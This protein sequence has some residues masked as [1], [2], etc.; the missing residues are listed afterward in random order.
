MRAEELAYLDGLIYTVPLLG[1]EVHAAG[2]HRRGT[3]L[4]RRKG[5]GWT[6]PCCSCPPGFE[7]LRRAW[8][9]RAAPDR[10]FAGRRPAH[11]GRTAIR[12]LVLLGE[13]GS[14]KTTTLLAAG[15]RPTP[16]P[17]RG[18]PAVRRC[19]VFVPLGDYT[20]PESAL[21]YVQGYFEE[22]RPLSAGLSAQ[23]AA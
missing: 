14:G 19:R 13:P 11:S 10:A 16:W 2:R 5:P 22:S 18:R 4:P 12:R 21:A 15:L 7:K 17:L 1:R 8:L 3:R 9:W 23:P 6:C 20:G